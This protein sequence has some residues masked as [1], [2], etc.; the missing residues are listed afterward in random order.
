[1]NTGLTLDL[2]INNYGFETVLKLHRMII[3]LILWTHETFWCFFSNFTT[4]FFSNHLRLLYLDS[5]SSTSSFIWSVIFWNYVFATRFV[6][7]FNS[8]G[9]VN[10]SRSFELKV[11]PPPIV[12][13][14]DPDT[15]TCFFLPSSAVV[16]S[17]C[18]PIVPAVV[19]TLLFAS[20][21]GRASPLAL[22][23]REWLFVC[24][25]S[26]RCLHGLR[27]TVSVRID[28]IVDSPHYP[29]IGVKDG[30]LCANV[31]QRTVKRTAA[32]A[33]MTFPFDRHVSCSDGTPSKRNSLLLFFLMKGT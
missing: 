24:A 13:L 27:P 17:F 21:C 28:W 14:S 7:P 31:H 33:R 30:S 15:P 5:I 23:S 32:G 18:V 8:N 26:A 19:F 6:F 20:L 29:L 22:F 12:R 1:M 16:V 4:H 11:T 25:P 9:R 2:L 3:F 10:R